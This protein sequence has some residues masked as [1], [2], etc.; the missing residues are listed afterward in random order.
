[1]SSPGSTRRSSSQPR[2]WVK[3][4]DD[5]R[6]FD[7]TGSGLAAASAVEGID[8]LEQSVARLARDDLRDAGEAEAVPE[9]QGRDIEGIDRHPHIGEPST[10][11]LAQELAH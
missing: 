2:R 11:G 6:G 5:N 10:A 3:P 9:A 8:Q 7:P 1:M 4:G